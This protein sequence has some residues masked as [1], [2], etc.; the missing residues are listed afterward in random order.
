VG[1]EANAHRHAEP[2]GAPA[3]RLCLFAGSAASFYALAVA[4]AAVLFT[5]PL[6]APRALAAPVP[7]AA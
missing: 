2:S 7:A 3:I 6:R 4:A 5:L 1:S